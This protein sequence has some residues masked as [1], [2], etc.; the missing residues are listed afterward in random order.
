MPRR[1]IILG[2][3]AR[4]A[5]FAAVRAGF[6]PYAIDL[7]ADSDLA[8]LC[9]AAPKAPWMYT[10]GLENHPRLVARLAE[11]RPLWGNGPAV[12]GAV[13][14]PRRLASVLAE[15]GF[16]APRLFSG[17]DGEKCRWLIK[18]LRGSAG[19]GVRFAAASDL[20]APPHGVVI[21]EYI[22]GESCSATFVAADG[23]AILLGVSR[24]LIGRDFG[25]DSEFL[26]A[27]SLAPLEL[28]PEES[29]KLCALGKALVECFR[30]VGLFGIDFLRTPRELWPVEINPRYTASI[31]MTER[32]TGLAYV[33]LHAAACRDQPL[34][35]Y[36]LETAPR[37]RC[38]GK[39]IVYAR[40][41]CRW[42]KTPV[43]FFE[44]GTGVFSWPPLA[45]IPQFEQ[46]FRA[47]QPMVTVFAEGE[48][49]ADVERQLRARANDVL[50]QF[51]EPHNA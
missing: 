27:G 17:V 23:G 7:F 14:D 1:L 3:S 22:E 8:A 33:A 32:V 21:Q 15:E 43:P 11:L 41:N 39:A 24:Q 49:L 31:E 34:L 25:L 19:R 28:R 6:E 38:T 50:S 2:A 9:A 13:R 5:A 4:A 51:V 46:A 47:G 35:P 10:G 29:A 30:L 42:Q 12:L 44:K 37:S 40:E 36:S 45:D 26:Y 18:P 16:A 48:S 20:T